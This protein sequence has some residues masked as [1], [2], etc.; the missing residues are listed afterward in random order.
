MDESERLIAKAA[1]ANPD[2]AAE[3]WSEWRSHNDVR[4]ASNILGW[5]GGY[6]SRNLELAGVPDAYLAGIY[7]HNWLVNN[8]KLSKLRSHMTVLRERWGAVPLKSFALSSSVFARGM[9]PVADFDF[10]VDLSK[11]KEVSEYLQSSGFLPL[12]DPDDG[13]FWGRII[14][15]RGSWN[16]RS[17]AGDDLDAHWKIFP[18]LSIGK[19][20]KVLREHT[21]LDSTGHSALT[22]EAMLMAL[23]INYGL[24]GESRFNGLFDI[25]E[26]ISHCDVG[27]VSRLAKE[28]KGVE[29]L[30]A[31]LKELISLASRNSKRCEELIRALPGPLERKAGLAFGVFWHLMVGG[32]KA[33]VQY[34]RVSHPRLYAFWLMFGRSSILERILIAAK[35][36]ISKHRVPKERCLEKESISLIGTHL[37]PG[38]HYLYPGDEHRWTEAPDARVAF[39]IPKGSTCC[40]QIMANPKHWKHSVFSQV[41]VFVNGKR[42]GTLTRQLSSLQ[43]DLQSSNRCEFV[44]VSIRPRRLWTI[45]RPGLNRENF[46]LAIPI[47]S[48]CLQLP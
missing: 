40:L 32:P 22:N 9:R 34:D 2:E 1:L 35:G 39:A 30:R 5:A 24:Q 29:S 47:V 28:V 13:E 15:Q 46:T 23:V 42:R 48:L 26:L 31:I 10:Y 3:S 43:L 7:R 12:L 21:T 38:W 36:P 25:H 6:I 20:R 18:H 11:L 8:L 14:P 17:R 44:E 33:P 27:R 19:N 41:G 45:A 4:Y 37:G 16:F